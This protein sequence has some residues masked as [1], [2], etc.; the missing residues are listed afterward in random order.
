MNPP[1]NAA[2]SVFS[3]QPV[4]SKNKPRPPSGTTMMVSP[5]QRPFRCFNF[6]GVIYKIATVPVSRSVCVAPYGS[7]SERAFSRAPVSI[8]H[9]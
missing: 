3:K 4:I 5:I 8:F 1:I 7:F 6:R 9:P 2:H